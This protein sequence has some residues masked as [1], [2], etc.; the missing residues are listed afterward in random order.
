MENICN[1]TTVQ[2]ARLCNECRK[3]L[4]QVTLGTKLEGGCFRLQLETL[5]YMTNPCS[6]QI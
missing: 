5:Q 1:H 3:M 4:M 2:E 6:A